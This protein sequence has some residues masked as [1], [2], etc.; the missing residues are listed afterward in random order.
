MDQEVS[1]SC[2]QWILAVEE[3]ARNGSVEVLAP[4]ALQIADVDIDAAVG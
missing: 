2:W 4:R 1:F 3:V